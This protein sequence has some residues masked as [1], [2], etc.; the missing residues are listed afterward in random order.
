MTPEFATSQALNR[1]YGKSSAHLT[2]QSGYDRS[3]A[4]ALT[5]FQQN[6]IKATRKQF[7]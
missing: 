6:L 4:F 1:G 2:V 5:D 7:P 3:M